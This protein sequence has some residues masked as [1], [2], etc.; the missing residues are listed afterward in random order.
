MI[1]GHLL[2]RG[3]FKTPSIGICFNQKEA[4][5]MRD[6]IYRIN[7]DMHDHSSQV[8]ITAKKGDNARSIYISLY[9]DGKPYVI[10]EGCSAVIMIKKPDGYIINNDCMIRLTDSVIIYEF[11]DQTV[12]DDGLCECEIRLYGTEEDL[13][14][15]PRFT[16]RVTP[17]VYDDGQVESQSEF[18]TLTEAISAVNNLDVD[19]SK[20]GAIVTIT[21]TKKDGTTQSVTVSDADFPL[22]QIIAMING[23]VD[24]ELGKGLSTNDYTDGDKAIVGATTSNLALKVDKVSGKG[25]SEED[26]TTEDQGIVASVREAYLAGKV[27][28]DENYSA[29][30]KAKLAS[31]DGGGAFII[32]F[33]ES[34]DT[35]TMDTTIEAIEEAY[36]KDCVIIG[37]F[38][39]R[40]YYFNFREKAA[41][42]NVYQYTYEL[43][44]SRYEDNELRNRT[45]TIVSTDGGDTF[46]V[47]EAIGSSV[48]CFTLNG[49]YSL[50]FR[51]TVAY[52]VG[53]YCIYSNALYR[54]N[55]Y[56]R[57][58]WNSSKFDKVADGSTL[59]DI[60]DAWKPTI[61]ASTTDISEGDP[62]TAGTFYAVYST[63]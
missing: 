44:F 34:S 3:G 29:E 32:T 23:K 19:V 28:S 49:A 12:A 20:S 1:T 40:A 61:V 25:L 35:I 33:S 41:I 13:V 5:I 42:N 45:L 46:T 26:Y 58:A 27:L 2:Y 52:S 53:S 7:L 15:S 54:C 10:E 4:N 39:G 30:E 36:Q 55:S 56:H 50:L 62:L 24:K 60:I 22:D 59:L 38:E 63:T 48:S 37:L 14:T 17:T 16:I 57:G 8:Q 6:S 47:T 9:E 43:T 18:T 11:T 51:G 21:V 31:L